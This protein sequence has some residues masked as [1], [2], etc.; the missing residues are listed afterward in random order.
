MSNQHL[1]LYCSQPLLRH[2]SSKGIYWFCS[3]CHQEIPDIENLREAK[4]SLQNVIHHELTKGKQ[5]EY[6]W[7]KT[8]KL[9]PYI[10][11]AEKLQNLALSDSLST[12][13]NRYR[14]QAYL[15]QEWQRMAKEQAPLSLIIGNFDCFQTYNN[16]Y[17]HHRGDRGDQYLHQLTKTIVNDLKHPLNLLPS[18]SGEEFFVILPYTTAEDA[19]QVAEEIRCRVKS[20]DI[21]QSNMGFSQYLTIS[22]GVA[23]ILPSNEYSSEMLIT[24]ATQ[25]LYQAK[26]QGRDRII[27]HE[28]LRRQAQV[29]VQEKSL[30]WSHNQGKTLLSLKDNIQPKTTKT[31]L[32]TT[33]VAYSVNSKI[34]DLDKISS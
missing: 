10:E 33:Y 19:V 27:I 13:A 4:L 17:G 15:D 20:L 24:A 12:V 30:A 23:S 28:Q 2:I 3:H 5:S 34:T 1:C 11:V 22:L 14:L 21:S 8:E 7:L 9:H 26:L 6:K 25:A 18:Y 16:T 31:K 29:I 32:L